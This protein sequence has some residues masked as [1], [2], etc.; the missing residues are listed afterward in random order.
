[1]GIAREH[2]SKLGDDGEVKGEFPEPS[3]KLCPQFASE[4]VIYRIHLSMVG[5]SSPSAWSDSLHVK[6]VNEN[7]YEKTFRGKH[8]AEVEAFCA[9]SLVSTLMAILFLSGFAPFHFLSP[10]KDHVIAT[11]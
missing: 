7:R 10:V 5:P 4:T 11:W 9:K 6:A 3:L 2:I 8:V 1:M